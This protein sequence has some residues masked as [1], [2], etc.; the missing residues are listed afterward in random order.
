MSEIMAQVNSRSNSA[1]TNTNG[2]NSSEYNNTLMPQ[3]IK[4]VLYYVSGKGEA[5]EAV[6]KDGKWNLGPWA[7]IY[8][9]S[10]GI[11]DRS[12]PE[13]NNVST[14]GNNFNSSSGSSNNTKSK[15]NNSFFGG[16]NTR[17]RKS[18]KSKASRKSRKH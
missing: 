12:V 4:G 2:S 3:E 14:S 15:S 1:G 10:K 17:K 5:W 13:P 8:K 9:P 6:K 16:K 18:R 7:G 11:I